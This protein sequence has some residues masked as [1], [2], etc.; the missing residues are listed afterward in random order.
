[1][2]PWKESAA[3]ESGRDKLRQWAALEGK[4]SA[5]SD[6]LYRGRDVPDTAGR[7]SLGFLNACTHAAIWLVELWRYF[8]SG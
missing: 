8:R 3:W 1:M 5:M 2:D 4:S 6:D 7:K